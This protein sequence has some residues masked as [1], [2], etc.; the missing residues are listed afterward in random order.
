M[1]IRNLKD[2]AKRVAE[3]LDTEEEIVTHVM[4]YQFELLTDYL[5]DPFKYS[6]MLLPGLGRF[7]TTTR[8]VEVQIKMRI[9]QIRKKP[10]KYAE[11]KELIT[12]L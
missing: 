6:N 7:H 2:V 12:Y 11:V 3:L 5:Q 1:V 10:E 9:R 4:R 8:L